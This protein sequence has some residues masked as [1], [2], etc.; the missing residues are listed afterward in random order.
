MALTDDILATWRNPRRVMARILD[1]GPREDR[2]LV[3]L[4]V[5]VLVIYVS[6][7]PALSRAAV[8]MPEAPLAQRLLAAFFGVLLLVPVAYPLAALS[9]LASR[10]A[11]GQGTW[12]G[13]RIA[14]FWALL[15]ISPLMLLRG[16]VA[17]L[18]GAG[19]QLQLLDLL[20]FAGFLWIWLSGLWV[21]EFRRI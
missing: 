6:L 4:L 1:A 16:L 8:L 15:A 2:A 11:G 10:A 21:A 3:F 18:I 17:G 14:L 13:A 5:A 7:W 12:H 9:H 19:V 20:V